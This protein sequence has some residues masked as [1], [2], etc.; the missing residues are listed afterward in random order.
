MTEIQEQQTKKQGSPTDHL[1]NE[2]TFLAW[3]RT[4]IAIMAFGF[5]VVKFSLFVKQLAL[6]FTDRPIVV[7]AKGYSGMIGIVLVVL[8]ASVCLLSYLQYKK[9]EHQ[10]NNDRYNSKSPLVVWLTIILLVG[11]VFLVLYL[12]PNV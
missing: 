11:S 7:P 10:L 8:G 12:L 6:L 1:A 5:V 4:A 3:V 2:R 9:T